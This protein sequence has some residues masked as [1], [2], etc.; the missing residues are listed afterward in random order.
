MF[1][2]ITP[3]LGV[4]GGVA[5][6]DAKQRDTGL[7]SYAVPNWTANLGLDWTTPI[8]GLN[9]GGRVVYTGKQWA[10]TGNTIELPSWH[11]FDLNARYATTISNTPV[12]FNLYVENL[13]GR[14]YWSGLFNDGFLMPASPRTVRLA[15]TFEF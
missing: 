12:T 6:M 4:L 2:Q 1:G 5:Y 9:V 14:E 8:T 15:A 3:T 13:T 10:D 11:R 7:D